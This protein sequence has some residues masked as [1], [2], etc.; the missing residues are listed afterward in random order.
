MMLFNFHFSNYHDLVSILFPFPVP[1][2]IQNSVL[3][4]VRFIVLQS[5]YKINMQ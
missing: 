1:T 3:H 5:A 4:R 2:D